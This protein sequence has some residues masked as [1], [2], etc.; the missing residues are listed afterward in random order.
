MPRPVEFIL[1]TNGPLPLGYRIVGSLWARHN[2]TDAEIYFARDS[3]VVG[4]ST[5]E[6]YAKVRAELGKT[7]DADP[8]MCHYYRCAFDQAANA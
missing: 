7:D 1:R 8:T 2:P 3:T 5:A 4:T 6:E